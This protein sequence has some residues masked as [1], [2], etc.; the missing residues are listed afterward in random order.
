MNK[1]KIKME[2]ANVA[3]LREQNKQKNRERIERIKNNPLIKFIMTVYRTFY[4]IGSMIFAIIV[5][6]IM[7]ML[8]ELS[9]CIAFSL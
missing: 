8:C 3:I 7:N 9:N 4:M 1:M 2:K 6:L 5:N